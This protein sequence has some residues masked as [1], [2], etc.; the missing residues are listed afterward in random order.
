M[1][2]L[3]D[4]TAREGDLD[5]R[6]TPAPTAREGIAGHARVAARRGESY[7]RELPLCGTWE[8]LALSG[9][10]DGY[11]PVANRLEEIKTYRGDLSRMAANQR[12]LHWAQ[13][14]VYG[15][16]LC[17]ERGLATV[18]L[19][20]VYL[21]IA[22]EQETV[23]TEQATAEELAGYLA[24][25]CRR[26]LAWAEQE[27]RHQAGR[28]D[29]LERLAFPHAAFRSGQRELAESAYKAAATGRCLLAQA[30]TG[31]GKT[32]ATL[33]PLLKA[34]PRHKI[35]RVAFLTMKTPG[36]R[37]AL[38]ALQQLGAQDP[39]ERLP[40]RV[41]ELVARTKA[42]EHPGRACHGE[43]CPL[44]R[45][46][47]DKLPA[48]RQAAVA[49]GWLDR[50]AL[51]EVALAHGVCPYY[52]GQELARWCDV[53]VGDVNHY[54]DA[55]ALLH[56]L[57]QANG[58]RLALLVDEAHNLVERA[59]GMYSAELLQRHFSRLQ[60]HSPPAV[61]SPLKRL[62]RQWQALL[63]AEPGQGQGG[64]DA[65]E[66]DYCLLPG[67]PEKLIAA[68]QRLVAAIT[69]HLAAHPADADPA[70]Q[71]CLFEAL[72]FLRL[73]ETFGEHSLV[74]L[75]RRG[76]GDSRLGLRNLVPADFLAAR[77]AAARCVV[78][79][80]ATLAPPAYHRDLLGLPPDT[81]W[82][83]VASPFQPEQLEVR[84]VTDLST[85]LADRSASHGRIVAELAGQYAARPGLYLAFFSSFAYLD[86]V[87]ERFRE[88]HPAIPAW[89]QQ[90]GMQEAERDAFLARFRLGEQG[91]GFAVLGGAFGEGIDLPGERLIGAFIATL[92]L[93]PFSPFQEALR[94]RLDA[95]FGR[96]YDY[97]YRIPG[98]VKVIQAAGRVI[99]GPE[100]HGTLL[101]LDDRFARR[102]N[103]ALMPDWWRL[104]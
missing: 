94:A 51:R 77:F 17:A 85:R 67:L 84:L 86:S 49:H 57:A 28:D 48:A 72:A 21:D 66:A 58:W 93:P 31:I 38:A 47:Y 35:D 29:A 13:V 53:V 83:S 26:F 80:S 62:I 46:F 9:R 24:G 95:R 79:F 32:L 10:A 7:Q 11:D 22:S 16:L 39:A 12:A 4:F 40:L 56:G 104:P 37:L 101:L 18:T 89:A 78:L 73:A 54:F 81:A 70:L 15:A 82:Q 36:R 91:I 92:G 50:E 63:R 44:A 97:A 75:A 71:E 59:R 43:A 1:R 30:P 55:S 6:F 25:L 68:L 3:C 103:R 102:E 34:M 88:A 99:R 42:C 52:L 87:L 96:G 60:R 98:L 19:A 33:F 5:H 45:G 8:G 20:L 69:D 27:V 23:L 76:R 61:A 41:L 74:D 100:D 14:R 90:R 2:T 65:F 64:S